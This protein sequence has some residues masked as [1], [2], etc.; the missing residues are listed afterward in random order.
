MSKGSQ[1]V[2]ANK[3]GGW[4]VRRSGAS[5]ASRVFETRGDAV[6]YARY[7]AQREGSELYVHAHDGTIRERDSYGSDPMPPKR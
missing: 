7:L 2:V 6:S 4:V 3:S 1:H 5:R